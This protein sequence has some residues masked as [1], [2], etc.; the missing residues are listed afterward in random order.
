MFSDD[1]LHH[2]KLDATF[3]VD[4]FRLSGTEHFRG[5]GGVFD[6]SDH[7][8]NPSKLAEVL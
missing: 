4:L 8:L 6:S 3:D 7:I 5:K 2:V 1:E